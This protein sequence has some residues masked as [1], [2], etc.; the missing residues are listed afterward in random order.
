M[1][2]ARK[3]D[4]A[5]LGGALALASGIIVYLVAT[6]GII[7]RD[8][9]RWVRMARDMQ[10][11]PLKVMAEHDQPPLYALSIIAAYH[12]GGCWTSGDRV[13]AWSYSAQLA[14][15][16]LG[17]LA[18]L[19]LWGIARLVGRPRVV[20]VAG[21]T[22]AVLPVWQHNAADAL[23]D[24]PHLLLFLT[25]VYLL[26]VATVRFRMRW[27]LLA[28]VCSGTAYLVRPEGT[29]VCVVGLIWLLVSRDI[30]R[31]TPAKRRVAGAAALLAGYLV[32][33]APYMLM[34]GKFTRKKDPFDLISRMLSQAPPRAGEPRTGVVGDGVLWAA[35]AVPWERGPLWS[36]AGRG[37]VDL[38]EAIVRGLAYVL[39]V[40]LVVTA[41][42]A[43]RS[44]LRRFPQRLLLALA[45]SY[46]GLLCCLRLYAGYVS[47]RHVLPMVAIC[48][49]WAAA[50]MLT[51][52]EWLVRL[53]EKTPLV[54]VWRIPAHRRGAFMVAGA[55]L[56]V[57]GGCLVRTLRPLRPHDLGYLR[58]GQWIRQVA[59]RGADV[60]EHKA[61]A[62]FYAEARWHT[63]PLF[64]D[65]IRLDNLLDEAE[66][67]DV[68]FLVFEGREAHAID[69]AFDAKLKARAYQEVHREPLGKHS[70]RHRNWLVVYRPPPRDR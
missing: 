4:R 50:G 49:P 59:G 57:L 30:R 37:T 26:L 53:A 65:T 31:Q 38:A 67:Q 32:L 52:V 58:T 7:S 6:T 35:I 42:G 61:W 54:Y 18:I 13:L 46:L 62:A 34:I 63:W 10:R 16:A 51:V 45:L 17:V 5:W 23:S 70:R 3:L 19:P 15:G 36:R 20:W 39:V 21:L 27:C 68:D 55:S 11:H 40:P 43:S 2:A 12:L 60:F 9:T 48:L 29:L 24:P 14:S 64:Y 56:I 66:R 41:G 47:A 1:L 25:G 28:G 69:P 33:A 22:A 44:H 8:G